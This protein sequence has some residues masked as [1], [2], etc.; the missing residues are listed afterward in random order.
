MSL[1]ETIFSEDYIVHSQTHG[2]MV[3]PRSFPINGKK[4][5]KL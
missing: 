1:K 3:K 2:N 5:M 4:R